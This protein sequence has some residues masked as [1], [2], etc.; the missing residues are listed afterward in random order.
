VS[1][2]FLILSLALAVCVTAAVILAVVHLLQVASNGG[3]GEALEQRGTVSPK[4]TFTGIVYYPVPYSAPPNLKLTATKRQYDIVKQDETGFT[5]KAVIALDDIRDEQRGNAE[6]M[7]NVGVRHVDAMIGKLKPNLQL[8][9]FN[10]EAKGVRPGRDG[11]FVQ[12]GTF[13][14]LASQEGEVNFPMPYAIAPNV[15]L[16][17]Q[18]SGAVIIMES[19]PTSFKWKNVPQTSP[20]ATNSGSVSWKAKGV[21]GTEIPQP[22]PQ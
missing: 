22:K 10:W 17:G 14:T 1:G 8:E 7:I 16:T 4:S 15:E 19:R 18:A 6:A 3:A 13:N 5:W 9:D 21:R 11:V 20:F 12:E 2:T